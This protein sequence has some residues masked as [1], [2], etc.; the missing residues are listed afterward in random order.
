MADGRSLTEK[1]LGDKTREVR[2]LLRAFAKGTVS[3][4]ELFAAATELSG[5]HA[6]DA[7]READETL[8]AAAMKLVTSGVITTGSGA[9]LLGIPKVSFLALMPAHGA[10]IP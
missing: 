10:S 1:I 9:G 4:G 5:Y 6:T 8:V 2:S 3:G 7:E